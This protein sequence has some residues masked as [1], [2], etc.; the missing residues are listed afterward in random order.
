[1]VGLWYYPLKK[2]SDRR[3]NDLEGTNTMKNTDVLGRLIKPG[4]V[5]G[6]ASRR[7]SQ[8]NLDVIIIR[9]L[10]A[11]GIKGDKL[12]KEWKHATATTLAGWQV[13]KVPTHRIVRPE[14][15][16]I[17]DLTEKE[18]IDLMRIR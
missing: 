17:T 3:V 1:M 4:D 13:R 16:I 18:A 9:E 10:K 5:C 2:V 15:L 8:T 6:F 7:G 14:H 12:V 11:D